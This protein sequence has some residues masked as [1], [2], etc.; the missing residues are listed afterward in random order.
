MLGFAKKV[1]A[2]STAVVMMAGGLVGCGSAAPK[3]AQ[4]LFALYEKVENRDNYKLDAKVEMTIGVLGQEFTIDVDEL[5]DVAGDSSHGTM[6]TSA[7]GQNVE[8]EVYGE[9][10]DGSYVQYSS[11]GVG[12]D[13]SW[14][15]TTTD[16]ANSALGT[17]M[18][19]LV[20]KDMLADAEFSVTD[21]GYTVTIPGSSFMKVLE[22]NQEY[23]TMLSSVGG[24]GFEAALNN[25][26][27]VID[28]DKEY[29]IVGL[30]FDV[31]MDSIAAGNAA[32]ATGANDATGSTEAT[33]AGNASDATDVGG[34]S[35]SNGTS[36]SE[37]AGGF[38]FSLD[39]SMALSLKMTLSDYG[40]VD[41]AS[42]AAPEEVKGKAF[43]VSVLAS[44]LGDLVDEIGGIV[45][46]EEKTDDNEASSDANDKTVENA[47]ETKAA[48]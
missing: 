12:E 47:E 7:F 34:A 11:T 14:T 30:T 21:T 17:S 3:S 8:S 5:M 6:V 39:A 31:T 33:D 46:D 42:V 45:A 48:A 26:V 1:V 36:D 22:N 25:S 27:A 28:F 10:V 40:T 23:A 32:A 20:T 16:I 15:K 38:S 35:D 4:E 13:A 29:K 2:F 37:S 9:V 19:S 44:D 18:D 41:P 43:D 24:E